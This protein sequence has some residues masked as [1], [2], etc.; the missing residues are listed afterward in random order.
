MSF[1]SAS[2]NAL[3][4]RAC[5]RGLTGVSC[6]GQTQRSARAYQRAPLLRTRLSTFAWRDILSPSP[7]SLPRTMPAA[8]LTILLAC[9]A[10]LVGA[11]IAPR[12]YDYYT[13]PDEWPP[14]CFNGEAQSPINIETADAESLSANSAV[15]V[16]MPVVSQPMVIN[17][18]NVLQVRDAVRLVACVA[19]QV[20]PSVRM[21]GLTGNGSH[22]RPVCEVSETL[23]ATVGSAV[24]AVRTN[25]R[26]LHA[27][28]HAMSCCT[29]PGACSEFYKKP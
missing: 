26:R 8:A 10:R 13:M 22:V 17:K 2:N 20:S 6:P 5:A 7:L 1:G 28:W 18:G 27:S 12:P 23:A 21:R 14:L 9:V 3:A 11:D 19:C 15:T 24:D 4:C 29:R 16:Q 25:K